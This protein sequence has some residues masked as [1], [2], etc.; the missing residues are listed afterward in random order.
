MIVHKRLIILVI[1]RGVLLF[2]RVILQVQF[3]SEDK[4][5]N[6]IRYSLLLYTDN[7]P[8]PCTQEDETVRLILLESTS[9]YINIKCTS[10]Y[11]LEIVQV[12]RQS[13]PSHNFLSRFLVLDFKG[14]NF[15]SDSNSETRHIENTSPN[16]RLQPNSLGSLSWAFLL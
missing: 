4:Q 11:P 10:S 2:C 14:Q 12:A 3:V 6:G 1:E 8:L 9:Y 16:P 7:L 5:Y 13:F 15:K